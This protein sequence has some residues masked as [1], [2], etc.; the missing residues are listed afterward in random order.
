MVAQNYQQ[1]EDSDA[2]RTS[3]GKEFLQLTALLCG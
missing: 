3:L 2:K 1:E